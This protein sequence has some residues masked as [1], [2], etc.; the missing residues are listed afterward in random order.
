MLRRLTMLA[1]VVALAGPAVAYEVAP[2]PDAGAVAGVVRFVG[3]PPRLDPLTV[4]RDREA[5]GDQKDAE[6][7]ALGPERGVRGSVVLVHGVTRGKKAAG[8]AVLDNRG[9]VFVSH[10]T[11]V[12]LGDRTRVKSSDDTLHHTRGTLG[13]TPVFNLA[14]PSREQMIDITRRLTSP[15]AIR[16]VCDAH[17]HMT[18]WLIVHDSPYHAVTDERGGYRIDGVP[19]GTYRISMWHEGYRPRG[20]DRDGRPLYDAPRTRTK[21]VTIAPGA[22]ATADF[23]LR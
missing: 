6:V 12:T 7:L 20:L 1:A 18:A 3:T 22:T 17:P 2:V 19:P 8:E 21:D 4:S 11:A 23:E 5:C 15:G 9:C 13:T 16:I 10:V 14:L